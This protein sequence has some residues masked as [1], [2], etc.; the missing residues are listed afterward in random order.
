MGWEQASGSDL[1]TNVETM[2][3]RAKDLGQLPRR[4]GR[5]RVLSHGP[6][7]TLLREGTVNSSCCRAH[8]SGVPFTWMK[9]QGLG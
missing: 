5:P 8:A 7:V 9:P 1:S 6:P 2:D 4:P 3:S